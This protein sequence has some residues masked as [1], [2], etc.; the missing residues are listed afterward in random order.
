M[1]WSLLLRC[2]WSTG[3]RGHVFVLEEELCDVSVETARG[4]PGTLD[5]PGRLHVA[6]NV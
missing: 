2:V 5:V 4:D 1:S 3:K 6:G